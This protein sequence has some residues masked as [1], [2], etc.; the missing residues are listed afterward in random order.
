MT[1]PA[2]PTP[3]QR[4]A[5]T[6]SQAAQ[7]T[8]AVVLLLWVAG[9]VDV[10]LNPAGPGTDLPVEVAVVLAGLLT[11]AAARWMNRAQPPQ[12]A[13]GPESPTFSAPQGG[14]YNTLGAPPQPAAPT[15]DL[16]ET[17]GPT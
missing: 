6:D 8:G 3:A 11:A 15:T 10:D 9:F 1:V 7:G 17:E 4:V 16:L 5:R 12:T 2:T 13:D 14:V